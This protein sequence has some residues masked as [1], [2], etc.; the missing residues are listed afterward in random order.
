MQERARQQKAAYE[1]EAH[2]LHECSA[3][4]SA[5]QQQVQN[6]LREALQQTHSLKMQHSKLVSWR[7][8]NKNMPPLTQNNNPFV[9]SWQD[10]E[11]QL[12]LQQEKMQVENSESLSTKLAAELAERIKSSEVRE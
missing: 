1:E 10:Q 8:C 9:S 7:A 12:Q 2:Y 11:M 4:A 5:Q 3:K 6:E